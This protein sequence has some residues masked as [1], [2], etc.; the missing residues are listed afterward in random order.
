M[1][2]PK[3]IVL[4][5]HPPKN[6]VKSAALNWGAADPTDR[7]PVI[8]SMLAPEQRNVIGVHSGAYGVY[9]ALA[10]AAGNLDPVHRPDLTNTAPPIDIGPFDKW[11]DPTA[12]VSLD[13]WGHLVAN[14]FADELE[15][16]LDVRPTIAVTKARITTTT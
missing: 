1:S 12:I 7:G 5:S 11:S 14:V 9:R 10:V 8:G 2:D 4:L 16:G 3:H 13:P 15:S 6:G